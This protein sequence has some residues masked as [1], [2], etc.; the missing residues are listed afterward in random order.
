MRR[1][2]YVTSALL[3]A[4]NALA[5]APQF[6]RLTAAEEYLAGE[7]EGFAV[8]S[9]GELRVAPAMKKVA[10][11]TDPFV[12]SQT[13]APNGDRFF[14]TGNDGKVYRL[15]GDELK[16][17]FTAPEPE[18]Y[19]VTFANGAL[20]AGTSPNGKI[21]R[22]DPE[23]GKHADWFDPKQAYIWDLETSGNDV[24]VA[25]GVE[26]KLFRVNAKG[27]GT[28]LYDSADTHIRSIAVRKD[29]VVLA[30]GSG[31][32]RIY[33]IARDGSAIALFESQLNEISSIYIDPS[34]T[35]WAAGV[36]NVLPSA[37]PAKTQTKPTGTQQQQSGTATAGEA[38]KEEP[39]VEVSFSFDDSAATAAA[40]SGASEIYRIEPDGFVETARKF[41]REMV[42]GVS[43]GSD[44]SILFATGPNGRIY[45][46]RNKELSL[47]GT[48]PEK[49]I[50]SVSGSGNTAVI[51][52]TNSGAVYRMEARPS[53][54]AEFRSS[55]KDVE[56]FSRFG[57]YRVEGR[58][59]ANGNVALAFRSGNT[60]TPDATWSNWS[61]PQTSLDG[62][63]NT[64]PARYI[65]WK[66]T[67][68]KP[69]SDAA[70]DGVTVAFMNR[71]VAPSIDSIAV[72]DPAVIFISSAYPSAPQ[73]VEATNP[74]EYGIFT[75]LDT[76]RDRVGTDPGKRMFR[77]GFR[78][79][80]WRATDDN[81]DS[82]RYSVAFR[83]KGSTTWLRLRD[84]IE[85][86]QMNF[87]TS[88]L[89]DGRY[90]L[91][92]TATDATDNPEM[93]LSD[94]KEGVEF[95]VDN[96]SPKIAVSSEG[97]EIVVNI[98]DELS[99]IG[100]VEYSADAEKWIRV[101]PIDGISDSRS[102]TFRLNRKDVDGKFVIVRA[103][104]AHYNVATASAK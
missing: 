76:P 52:T 93:A 86:N 20:L 45:E 80:M 2:L 99:P 7:L 72:Q 66:L 24:L 92:L 78:T 18:I 74:D 9:R 27:E 53:P 69:T 77:K 101:T 59:L 40:Q 58:N 8:T 60:R 36:S 65:Q 88:Q 95:Q 103:T 70:I 35:A 87:D 82:L 98:T 29:G 68:P 67:M 47:L 26:G 11:F 10:T 50:V 49:Q 73:V 55:A 79:V 56:R 3:F 104:D 15:R 37:A 62:N 21:Y 12:L 75:S 84:N 44:G 4:V 22:V 14:G 30:G 6:W 57:N 64:P 81:G 1:F 97:N 13:T 31:K 91:R 54:T 33:Q 25:T 100:R 89:P 17:L 42:Y 83:A 19:A 38:K 90:E 46:L 16:L 39:T 51:T 32:G 63:I 102:E 48:V 34:G 23:T 96:T 41:D 94:V 61:A 28:V 5:V 71:N 43:G 85:E